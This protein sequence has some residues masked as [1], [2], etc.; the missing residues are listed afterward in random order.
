MTPEDNII[1]QSWQDAKEHTL[2]ESWKKENSREHWR[3]M[4]DECKAECAWMIEQNRL[5]FLEQTANEVMKIVGEILLG[6]KQSSLLVDDKQ[7]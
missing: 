3:A 2:K 5:S 4:L 1:W 6:K 7:P